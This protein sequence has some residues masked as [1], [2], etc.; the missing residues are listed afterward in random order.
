MPCP[1]ERPVK[2]LRAKLGNLGQNPHSALT[3]IQ[4]FIII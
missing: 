3:K 1:V 4:L 2:N